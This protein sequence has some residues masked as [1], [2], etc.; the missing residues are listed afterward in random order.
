MKVEQIYTSCLSQ[1]A[2][3]IES[4]G[5]AAVID[6]L[7]EISNYLKLA[8][9]SNSKIK[10][11]FE[12]HFHADFISGHLTLAKKTGAKIVYGPQADPNFESIIAEDNQVFKI[13]AVTITAV[14]TPGASMVSRGLDLAYYYS[15]SRSLRPGCWRCKLRPTWCTPHLRRVTGG[16]SKLSSCFSVLIGPPSP[17]HP[18]IKPGLLI[19]TTTLGLAVLIKLKPISAS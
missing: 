6:P 8:E 2:Y 5:E 13:G 4:N 17:V 15:S 3:F 18:T 1:G 12:T 7:R 14:H 10:Y 9:D 16:G 11:V 19:R